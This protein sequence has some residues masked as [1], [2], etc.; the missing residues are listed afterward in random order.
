VSDRKPP[1]LPEAMKRQMAVRYTLFGLVTRR[2]LVAVA[3]VLSVLLLVVVWISVQFLKPIPPRR[4]VLASGAEYGLYHR[5]AQ[6]YKQILARSGVVV[7]ERTTAGAAENLQLLLDASKH[8][9]V[10]FMQGGVANAAN[11][12][13]VEM[14]AALYYEPLWIFA[15]ANEPVAQINQLGGKRI[16]IGAPGSGTRTF[17]KQMLS[18]NGIGEDASTLLEMGSGEGLLMVERGGADAAMLVG[19]ADTPAIL[20]ALSNPRLLL[21]SMARADAYT[22][23]FRR[24]RWTWPTAYPN[25]RSR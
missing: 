12:A 24:A 17:V 3:V 6:R 4:I 1:P 18:A 9:D 8:V 25:E 23:R 7:E 19:G 16:V 10:A 14:V 22:R 2:E 11:A 20:E 21:V 13:G 15:R 5:Y